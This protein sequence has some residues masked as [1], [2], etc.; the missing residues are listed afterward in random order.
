MEVSVDD[1]GRKVVKVGLVQEGGGCDYKVRV[2]MLV[3]GPTEYLRTFVYV[4]KKGTAYELIFDM[5]AGKALDMN[6]F[7]GK[8][9]SPANP[10]ANPGIRDAAWLAWFAY[11]FEY[12][13][14]GITVP[15]SAD[16]TQPDSGVADWT[17]KER[18]S[19]TITPMKSACTQTANVV[20]ESVYI[21][22]PTTYY[23][24][25]LNQV[26][27]FP[28]DCAAHLAQQTT[29]SSFGTYTAN[30]VAETNYSAGFGYGYDVYDGVLGTLAG[31]IRFTLKAATTVIVHTYPGSFPYTFI[32]Q[33][34]SYAYGTDVFGLYSYSAIDSFD[35]AVQI[36]AGAEY[37]AIGT[38]VDLT[39]QFGE[40]TG[41]WTAVHSEGELFFVFLAGTYQRYQIFNMSDCNGAPGCD[42]NGC[43]NL[44]V[45]GDYSSLGNMY[46]IMSPVS[47]WPGVCEYSFVMENKIA[48]AVVVTRYSDVPG[49][50]MGQPASATAIINASDAALSRK[51]GAAVANLVETVQAAW[52]VAAISVH[53]TGPGWVKLCKLKV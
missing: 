14:Q 8:A 47:Y 34:K 38:F 45:G 28:E 16:K 24:E 11:N 31:K 53:Q 32:E 15:M 12:S 50:T 4:Y 20:N 9:G 18:V 25:T 27:S 5:A 13:D 49:L 40:A 7:V 6:T 29:W 22:E 44:Y 35:W 42:N 48:P 2:G 30:S 36:T 19:G 26:G 33:G 1:Q 39:S 37:K 46:S 17:V 23:R 3:D 52:P 43:Y 10:A 21:A 51:V 41:L